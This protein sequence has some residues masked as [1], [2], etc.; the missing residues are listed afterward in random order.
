[1]KYYDIR[2]SIDDFDFSTTLNGVTITSS[3]S[4]PYQQFSITF[5]LDS[6]DASL[7][8]L[9]DYDKI[10]LEIDLVEDALSPPIETVSFDL[11]ALDFN[12]DLAD[13]DDKS[14]TFGMTE[15]TSVTLNAISKQSFINMNTTVNKVF[16][17]EEGP[18]TG[19][20]ILETISEAFS[21]NIDL[22]TES[23]S[24]NSAEQFVLP[25][26]TYLRAIRYVTQ[27]M[28]IHKDSPTIA[29]ARAEESDTI[30]IENL[31]ANI[32]K[33]PEMKIYYVPNGK[34]N[35]D[36]SKE[37]VV[38]IDVMFVT[39][40]VG[41]EYQENEVLMQQ[42]YNRLTILK[43]DNEF[44]KENISNYETVV[45]EKGL[46]SS[47]YEGETTANAGLKSRTRFDKNYISTLSEKEVDRTFL[48]SLVNLNRIQLGFS[49]RFSLKKLMKV[50]RAME[51]K[52]ESLKYSLYQGKYIMGYSEIAL[53]P[54]SSGYFSSAALIKLFR[55]V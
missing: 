42:G 46:K 44:F 29:I 26:M 53:S 40:T 45:N 24:E 41:T 55:G 20:Q 52:P 54:E 38:G 49:G 12:Y 51:F 32:D 7:A 22:S 27:Y 37:G 17:Y 16:K 18:Y 50:G 33:T 31:N 14:E 6:V 35:P 23:L 21:L 34:D 47:K 13:I 28:G 9:V 8:K 30:F 39:S 36:V 1:M 2:F 10:K 25:P 19:K 3:T 11:I 15:T 43:P 5:G 4:L 48:R